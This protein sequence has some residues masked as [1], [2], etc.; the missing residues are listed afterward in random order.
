MPFA[1]EKHHRNSQVKYS[2]EIQDVHFLK[3]DY[4]IPTGQIADRFLVEMLEPDGDDSY[5]S[6][7]FF[8]AIL[9][10]KEYFSDYRWNDIAVEYLNSNPELKKEFESRLKSDSSFSGNL[11]QQLA[12]IY[13]RSTYYESAFRRYP[14]YRIDKPSR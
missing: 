14:V 5:F 4:Y 3:G 1:Y 2:K 11:R 12:Y 13:E 6:W 10:Q 8:D 9:Q 7:N